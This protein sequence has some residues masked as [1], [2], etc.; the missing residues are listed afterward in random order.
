MQMGDIKSMFRNENY[1]KVLH[2]F[3]AGTS[4]WCKSKR[5]ITKWN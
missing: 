3:V 2:L 4:M 5:I 1:D